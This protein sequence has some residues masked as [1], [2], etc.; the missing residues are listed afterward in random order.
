MQMPLLTALVVVVGTVLVA[1][2]AWSRFNAVIKPMSEALED[3]LKYI[4][5]PDHNE[6][7][8]YQ[9]EVRKA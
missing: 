2:V 3:K 5:L 1:L 9:N 7:V 8:G 4:S 6:K